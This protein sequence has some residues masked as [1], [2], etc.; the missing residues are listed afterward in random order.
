MNNCFLCQ[1][2]NTGFKFG[3]FFRGTWIY[4]KDKKL[5]GTQILHRSSIFILSL[6]PKWFLFQTRKL[7]KKNQAFILN[8]I[9]IQLIKKTLILIYPCSRCFSL[10]LLVSKFSIWNSESGLNDH[11]VP[12]HSW[13]LWT[14]SQIYLS[15]FLQHSSSTCSDRLLPAHGDDAHCLWSL[16]GCT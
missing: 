7:R 12:L 3:Y 1:L 8:L 11:M 14:A 2:Q 16:P 5:L 13:K 4:S 10:H 9:K 6:H 15:A